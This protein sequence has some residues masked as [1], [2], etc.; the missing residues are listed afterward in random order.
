MPGST[1][2]KTTIRRFWLGALMYLGELAELRRRLAEFLEDARDRGNLYALTDMRARL[3]LAWLIADEPAEGRRQLADAMRSWTT[4][5]YHVQHFNAL[6]SEVQADLYEGRP[7]AAVPRIEAVWPA[8]TRSLLMR[9]QLVR[10]E[11]HQLRARAALATLAATLA[12]S[13]TP[14]GR[15]D[16]RAIER[17]IAALAAEKMPWI[18]PLADLLRAG[19]LRVRGRPGA[20]IAPL[21]AAIAALRAQDMSLHAAVAERQLGLLVGGDEGTR[22]RA[23]AE[24]WMA[25]QTVRDPAAIARVFAPGLE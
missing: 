14:P 6:L 21:R 13:G 24:S 8:L 9:I 4:D 15:D 23:G 10:T 16:I 5:G 3:N 22:L 20:A 19:L 11:A 17:E 18:D 1:W 7:G 25:A 12:S 2:A